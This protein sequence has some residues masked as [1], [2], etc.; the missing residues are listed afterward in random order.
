MAYYYCVRRGFG[1]EGHGAAIVEW[2]GNAASAD[3]A[4]SHLLAEL[5]RQF[6][7]LAYGKLNDCGIAPTLA[8]AAKLCGAEL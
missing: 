1:S 3:E 6:G 8:R 4:E 2:E 5:E 7:G